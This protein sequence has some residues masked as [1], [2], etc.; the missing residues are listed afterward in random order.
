MR[1]NGG[2]LMRIWYTC[3]CGQERILT[4][5]H[6]VE[7]RIC[8]LCGAPINPK[9]VERQSQPPFPQPVAGF[10][11]L[12]KENLEYG[13]W[14]AGYALFLIYVVGI[15]IRREYGLP[16]GKGGFLEFL[17]D[18]GPFSFIIIMFI[19]NWHYIQKQ[20]ERKKVLRVQF[21]E[22]KAADQK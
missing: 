4:A 6:T 7:P 2:S 20:E 15:R 18:W 5:I 19:Q 13:Y 12:K 16:T 22:E 14:W 17:L 8:A 11:W 1:L 9:Y 3:R 10:E 21:A